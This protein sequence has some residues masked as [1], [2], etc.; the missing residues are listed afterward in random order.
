MVFNLNLDSDTSDSGPTTS[1]PLLDSE[2]EP[3]CDPLPPPPKQ[4]RTDQGALN[5]DQEPVLA[6][7]NVADVAK[8]R[9]TLTEAE[10][11]NFYC[12]HFYPGV[13]FKFPREHSRSFQYQYLRRYKWLVYS[14]QQNGGFCLPCVLFARN[15]LD[16]RKGRGTF[17]DR[18]FTNFKKAYDI[19]NAHADCQY[20]RVLRM[21]EP[22]AVA[23]FWLC[24]RRLFLP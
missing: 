1:V 13:D 16:A 12:N 2:S 4:P 7:Y 8:R 9:S 3:P 14:Q 20:H 21:R 6:L 10:K 17:V 5:D 18:A 15:T 19:C 24:I 11:Y 23:S 22:R